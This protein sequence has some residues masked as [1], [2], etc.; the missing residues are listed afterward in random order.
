[1]FSSHALM[2]GIEHLDVANGELAHRDVE[3]LRRS[4]CR[5]AVCAEIASESL[6]RVIG[7]DLNIDPDRVDRIC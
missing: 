1:M 6:L 3:S 7:G 4:R 2:L 5:P